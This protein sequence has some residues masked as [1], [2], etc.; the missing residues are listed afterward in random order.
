M[1]RVRGLSKI[2][3]EE[4]GQRAARSTN[5]YLPKEGMKEVAIC[6]GCKALYWNKRWYLDENESTKLSLD[7]VKNEVICPACQ[8][9]QDNNPAGI[10]TFRGDYLVEHENDILNAIKNT[11]EKSRSKNPLARI[12]EIRKEGNLLTIMTTDDKLAQKLGRDIHKA[13]SGSLEY[14]WNK[15]DSFVRVNWS[16]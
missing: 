4:K 14:K 12:M 2:G 5:A 3:Y 1:A 16:R 15:E 8:R 10:V 6:T 9:V 7:M 13:H 11:E